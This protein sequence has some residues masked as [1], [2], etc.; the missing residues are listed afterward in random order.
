[1]VV[2]SILFMVN[3]IKK[4]YLAIC[5]C[6]GSLLLSICCSG[7]K[8][9][10]FRHQSCGRRLM[11]CGCHRRLNYRGY[12]Q[13]WSLNHGCLHCSCCLSRDLNL[14]SKRSFSKAWCFCYSCRSMSCFCC[15]SRLSCCF[16]FR[17]LR[18]LKKD[19]KRMS[20]VGVHILSWSVKDGCCWA[21][22]SFDVRHFGCPCGHCL[23]L[24]DGWQRHCPCGR[25]CLL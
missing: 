7:S 15:T 13:S 12:R 10:F 9:I 6:K 1:M 21:R 5:N 24:K 23:S 20:L 3:R 2:V 25:W 16:C 11:S 14:N 8:I 19:V 17:C 22:C 4:D 18:Q